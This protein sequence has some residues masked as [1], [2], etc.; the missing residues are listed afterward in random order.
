MI[1][2]IFID[3]M[4]TEKQ[5]DFLPMAGL[6][7]I[8]RYLMSCLLLS[9]FSARAEAPAP[10]QEFWNYFVEFGDARGELFDPAD[11]AAVSNLP[12]KAKQ[13]IDKASTA[14]PSITKT[15]TGKRLEQVPSKTQ[16]AQE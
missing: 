4:R 10:S 2:A 11:Y 6:S 7:A 12:E 1:N 5:H 15:S 3:D 16:S 9:I 13:E 14:K 8:F